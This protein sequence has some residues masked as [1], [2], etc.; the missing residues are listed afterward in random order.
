MAVTYG[1]NQRVIKRNVL[2]LLEQWEEARN[3]DKFLM[4]KY[5]QRYDGINT[6]IGFGPSFLRR[7]TTPETITRAR[8][9]IQATGLFEPTD[10]EVRRKRRIR[11]EEARAHHATN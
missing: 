9:T 2:E 7:A 8:R 6:S 3:D 5:W 4:L 10:P 11:E 1:E